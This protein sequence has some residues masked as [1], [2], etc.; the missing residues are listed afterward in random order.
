M[1]GNDLKTRVIGRSASGT[2]LRLIVASIAV[3]AI[4]A[5]FDISPIRFWQGIFDSVRGLIAAIGDSFGEI[6]VNLTTY[7]LLGAA[8][9]VPIWLVMRLLRGRRRK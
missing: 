8:I 4:L 2:I 7:L 5:V 6:I 1:A 9:V 3:G